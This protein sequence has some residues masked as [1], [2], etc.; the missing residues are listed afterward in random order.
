M[1]HSL[2]RL[3]NFLFS[4]PS[5]G[6]P[7]T[8]RAQPFDHFPT[9]IDPEPTPSQRAA[10]QALIDAELPT[11]PEATDHPLMPPF[12]LPEPSPLLATEYTRLASKTALSGIDTSRYEAL[13]A[14]SD[15]A[16]L[17]SWKQTL[18]Q[19]YTSQTYLSSRLSR[20]QSLEGS[21]K[22]EWLASNEVLVAILSGLEKEL[23]GTKEGID[24]VVLE[25]QAAQGA[26]KGE[27]ATLE[28]SWREG[29][30]RVLETEVAAE[31]LRR[32]VLEER[33]AGGRA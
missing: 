33:R 6:L 3:P 24:R 2:V 29:V 26:V 15:P 1:T 27:I 32:R 14:P 9:D 21:G 25:R 23:Q 20:L 31:G 8:S 19:A 12:E 17:E 30:G 7:P 22:E 18:A 4:S 10:A 16:S 5:P 13:D 11:S 28:R